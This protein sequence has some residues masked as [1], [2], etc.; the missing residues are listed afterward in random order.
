MYLELNPNSLNRVI[1][2]VIKKVSRFNFDSIAYSGN[3]GALIAIPVAIFLKKKLI[4]VRKPSEKSHGSVVE[5][6]SSSKVCIIIDDFIETGRT[7]RRIKNYL[8]D[9]D[10]NIKAILLYNSSTTQKEFE[11]IKLVRC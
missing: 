1:K 6:T 4:I 8:S 11:K 10:I 3:S 9:C 5:K 2:R 7:L